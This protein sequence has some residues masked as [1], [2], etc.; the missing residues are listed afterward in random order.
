M[1]RAAAPVS[2]G[3]NGPQPQPGSRA[4]LWGA[5]QGQRVQEN[6]QNSAVKRQRRSSL[7]PLLSS[8]SRKCEN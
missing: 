5:I 7:G 4:G 8:S 3:E 6:M 2:C 1:G